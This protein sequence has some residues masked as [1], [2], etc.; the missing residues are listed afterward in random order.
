METLE[1]LLKR[2]ASE[3]KNMLFIPKSKKMEKQKLKRCLKTK[4]QTM[5]TISL[6][7]NLKKEFWTKITTEM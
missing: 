7:L 2:N 3:L 4:Y 1:D 5:K 6:E